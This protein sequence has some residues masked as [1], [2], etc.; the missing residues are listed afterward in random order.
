MYL[1][2]MITGRRNAHV[3]RTKRVACCAR[4]ANVVATLPALMTCK[5]EL[6]SPGD[7]GDPSIVFFRVPKLL[8]SVEAVTDI[9]HEHSFRLVPLVLAFRAFLGCER[10]PKD[11][12]S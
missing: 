12:T 6:I 10:P 3:T 9:V 11:I 4:Y 8:R 7:R 5:Q 2:R 1:R